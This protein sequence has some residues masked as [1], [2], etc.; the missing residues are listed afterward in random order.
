MIDTVIH[1]HRPMTIIG[2]GPLQTIAAALD[3]DPSIAPKSIFVGMQGSVFKGYGGKDKP[4]P[5]WNVA[6]NV[7]SA[8]KVFAAPWRRATITPLDTCGLPQISLDAKRFAELSQSSDP[9]AG[10]IVASYAV[11]R[12]SEGQPPADI[13]TT[14]FDTVAIYLADP[15]NNNLLKTEPLKISVTDKGLTATSATGTEMD[16][17]TSWTDVEEY[18]DYLL[19]VLTSPLPH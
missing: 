9:L 3:R 8:K 17:A 15:S 19:R 2:I 13:S 16:V 12:K 7:P 5:E 10:A 1:S 4:D 14:L 18:R 11:W 6:S